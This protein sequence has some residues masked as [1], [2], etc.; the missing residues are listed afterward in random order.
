M[1]RKMINYMLIA[2]LSM[3]LFMPSWG[4]VIPTSVWADFFGSSTLYNGSPVP[5]GSIIDA[6]DPDGLH[7]GT[8]IASTAG[9][10]G[11]MP[12]YG[13]DDYGDG[14]E[15]GETITFYI[16]GRLAV[17][18]GP[19][20]PVWNGLGSRSE[21]NLSASAAVS[22]EAVLMPDDRMGSPGDTVRY[23]ATVKNTGEGIDF[24]FVSGGSEHGWIIRPMDELAYADPDTNVTVYFD[25]L[26]PKAIFYDINDTVIWRV[27]SGVDNSVFIEDTVVT[28]VRTATDVNEDESSFMPHEFRLYQN[29][30]NPF[31]PRTTIFFDLPSQQGVRLQ[32][33]DLLGRLAWQKDLGILPAGSHAID[34]DGSFLASGMYF[35]RLKADGKIYTRKMIL[36]K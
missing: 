7:C 3:I 32:V 28:M 25:L 16:N 26:I 21:V 34:F 17:P 10:Y 14:A 9:K 6:Y 22:M 5:A 29:F 19:D 2:A 33:F 27:I 1:Q 4:E 20:D 13:R 12:V 23:Y 8:T 31:N 30:P 18:Q 15:L 35:Y 11:F 36:L 24:Y